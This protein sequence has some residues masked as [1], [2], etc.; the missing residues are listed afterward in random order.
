MYDPSNDTWSQGASY[1]GVDLYDFVLTSQGDSVYVMG[2]GNNEVY[3]YTASSNQWRTA[4]TNPAPTRR[5]S[6]GGAANTG[7]GLAASAVGAGGKA[8]LWGGNDD[9]TWDVL[10]DTWEFDFA[11]ESWMQVADLPMALTN[12]AGT[13]HGDRVLVFGGQNANYQPQNQTWVYE[14]EPTTHWYYLPLVLR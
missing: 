5:F 9:A 6:A 14:P 3:V 11:T 4:A 2:M 12:S 13:W 8:W 7:G 1:P 10:A